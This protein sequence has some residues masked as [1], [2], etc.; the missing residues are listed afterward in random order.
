MNIGIDLGGSHIGVGLIQ[1]GKVISKK[2]KDISIEDN[3]IKEYIVKSIVEF[4]N[5]I[6]EES[7]TKIADI[8]FIGISTPGVVKDNCIYNIVN[9]GID[10]FKIAEMLNKYIN[11]EIRIK[12]D[13]KCAA[14]AEFKYGCMKD[15]SNGI[16]FTI[17]TGI[18]GAA[19]INNTLIES[20]TYPGT[21]FGHMVIE[22]NGRAC[23]CK[24]YG[25]FETYAS[26]KALKKEIRKQYKLDATISSKE[27]VDLIK[28]DLKTEKMNKII[29]EYVS[30]LAI[31]IGNLINI[32]EPD[33]IGLGG[34]IVYIGDIIVEKLEKEIL[35]KRLLFNKRNTIN[36]QIAILGNDAGMIGA[37]NI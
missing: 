12:N 16:F 7:M 25:C 22:K 21:E 1:E 6:L 23:K 11:K 28:K 30:Y 31:G 3:N 33:V 4:I 37:A 15:N 5:E 24:N 2:E 27:I 14:I 35:E 20:S 36:I 8:E 32:F 19:F 17:G 13:A 34:S 26:M 9:L 10:E 29:D 18:G